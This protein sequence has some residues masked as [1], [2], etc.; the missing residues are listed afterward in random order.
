MACAETEMTSGGGA[1]ATTDGVGPG[2]SNVGDGGSP[3][4]AAPP[5]GGTS[6][7]LPEK[8]CLAG[9]IPGEGGPIPGEGGRG[10]VA[11]APP[12]ESG[13]AARS[14][15]S[16]PKGNVRSAGSVP[17]GESKAAT[18]VLAISSGAL[19]AWSGAL[20]G[21]GA[22]S[23]GR[24]A[25]VSEKEGCG[26]TTTEVATSSLP[27]AAGGLRMAITEVVEERM[28]ESEEVKERASRPIGEQQRALW[29]K[30]KRYF[31]L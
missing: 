17:C 28:R 26:T 20:G 18:S 16:E 9:P 11:A 15:L 7:K 14:L 13:Q 3:A 30:V 10:A 6:A 25:R 5:P 23:S 22:G 12:G 24:E 31:R 21:G 29:L 4:C 2:R 27:G 19:C 1:G 8:D